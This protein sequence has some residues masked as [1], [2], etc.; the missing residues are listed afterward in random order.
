MGCVAVC[1]R[2]VC[3]WMGWL[4]RIFSTT[5]GL[6][7]EGDTACNGFCILGIVIM[8]A[9]EVDEGV[10]GLLL[11][12]SDVFGLWM[13]TLRFAKLLLLLLLY[14]GK[15]LTV[16]ASRSVESCSICFLL[17]DGKLPNLTG[18]LFKAFFNMWFSFWIVAVWA[19]CCLVGV[20]ALV[21][22]MRVGVVVKAGAFTLLSGLA[23]ALLKSVLSVLVGSRNCGSFLYAFDIGLEWS[24]MG[25]F[26]LEFNALLTSL[27]L[28]VIE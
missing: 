10:V 11:K 24:K 9:D 5:M 14:E 7:V 6:P 27:S 1:C 28:L 16:E 23:L 26:S 4:R 13:R 20:D 3:V 2:K 19:V 17:F 25:L 18:R 21:G 12:R 15:M 22:G 8:V